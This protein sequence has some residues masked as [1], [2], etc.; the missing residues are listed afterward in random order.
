MRIIASG[1]SVAIVGL[2]GETWKDL[3]TVRALNFTQPLDNALPANTI[4]QG[5]RHRKL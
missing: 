3:A 5:K 4:G 2:E 1:G